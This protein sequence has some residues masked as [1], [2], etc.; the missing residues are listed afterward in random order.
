MVNYFY[1][2]CF[3]ARSKCALWEASDASWEN[4]K[5]RVNKLID[6]L[7]ANPQPISSTGG[8]ETVITGIE[9]RKAAMDPLY[10][11]LDF[12]EGLATLLHDAMQGNYTLLLERTGISS[13]VDFCSPSKVLDYSWLDHANLAV[14]CGDAKDVRTYALSYWDSFV[15]RLK[16]LSPDIGDLWAE[17]TFSCSGWQIRPK[18]RFEGP[19][20]SPEADASI[21]SGRPS[22]PLLLLSSLYDP[23]TPLG[24]ATK[25]ARGHPGSRVLLQKSVGHC[26]FLSA[27]SECTKRYVREY[28]ETGRIPPEGTECEPDCVPWRDC[29]F[30]RAHLPR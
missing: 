12:F 18:Y 8:P 29:P 16:K 21:Q 13:K 24:C 30:E 17:G 26:A 28:M 25:V 2:T 4:I 5:S 14:M 6:D 22:A 15:Q 19:F 11:P 20:T 9:V 3:K 23:V 27:P 1:K 7:D 10:N